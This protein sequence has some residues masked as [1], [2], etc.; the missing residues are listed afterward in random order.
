MAHILKVGM[1]QEIME[2][3]LLPRRHKT[4]RAYIEQVSGRDKGLDDQTV[5]DINALGY[6][7]EIS[8][9]GIRWTSAKTAGVIEE[10][11]VHII[12]SIL[13]PRGYT[14]NGEVEINPYCDSSKETDN[15]FL[16]TI[17]NNVI[18]TYN[19]EIN[20]VPVSIYEHDDEIPY[21]V[22]QCSCS[23]EYTGVVPCFVHGDE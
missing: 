15:Y 18:R 5:N 1:H 3:T 11:V 14:M 20:C 23:A 10:Q 16:M 8:N 4:F 17:N 13:Q 7:C 21:G 12:K 9:L 2:K 19:I 6:P 22:P